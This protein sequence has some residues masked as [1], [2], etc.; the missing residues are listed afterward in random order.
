MSRF[1][2][3]LFL[4][5]G[6]NTSSTDSGSGSETDT[7]TDTDSDTDTDTDTDTDADTDADPNPYMGSW[8]GSLALSAPGPDGNVTDICIGTSTV[9][10]TTDGVVSGDGTCEPQNVPPDTEPPAPPV[11]TIAGNVAAD[12]AYVG[13]VSQPVG[14]GE[15]VATDATGTFSASSGSLTWENTVTGPEEQEVTLTGTVVVSKQ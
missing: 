1:T 14:D 9:A 4:A 3:A 2:L 11:F 6:C 8:A 7:D 15:P 13:T 5:L 12:G 10:I